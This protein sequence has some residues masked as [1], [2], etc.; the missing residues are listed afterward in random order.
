M[1]KNVADVIDYNKLL[2]ELTK[3]VE[4]DIYNIERNIVDECTVYYEELILLVQ[5]VEQRK[6]IN[7][8]SKF[9][10]RSIEKS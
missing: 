3:E 1:R 2:N 8:H 5:D 4:Q 7:L 9:I 10:L 6:N